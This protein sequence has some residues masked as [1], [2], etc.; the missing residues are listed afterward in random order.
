MKKLFINIYSNLLKFIP[1]KYYDI[2]TQTIN[3][4]KKTDVLNYAYNSMGILKWQ[5][6]QL[7]GEEYCYR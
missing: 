2:Y 1:K 5:N 7:S 3:I 6:E 4:L